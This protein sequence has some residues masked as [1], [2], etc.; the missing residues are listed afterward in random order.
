MG[1]L[2]KYSDG[3]VCST[4]SPIGRQCVG[5]GVIRK[6]PDLDTKQMTELLTAVG[7]LEET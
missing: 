6:D 7:S 5:D 1:R 4:S 2:E 3:E